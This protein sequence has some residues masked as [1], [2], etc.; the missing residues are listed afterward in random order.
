MDV[1]LHPEQLIMLDGKDR[2]D[3]LLLMA[4]CAEDLMLKAV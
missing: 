2:E 1:N 3:T 4:D